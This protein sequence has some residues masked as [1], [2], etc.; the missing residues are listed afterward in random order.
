M[1][2]NIYL[3]YFLTTAHYSW[4]WLGIWVLFYLNFT[5]YTGIGWIETVLFGSII[6]A[7][8]P[9]GAIGDL[10][11]K[12]KTLFVSFVLATISGFVMAYAQDLWG[13][14]ISMAIGAVGGALYSGTSEAL[15]Y[16]SLKQES[17]EKKFDKIIANTT[18]I[19]FLIPAI[20][21]VIGGFVY[22]FDPKMPFILNAVFC[23]LGAVACLFLV[24]PK[25]DSEVFSW[26]NFVNQTK[27]GFLQLTKSSEMISQVALLLA[28]STIMVLVFEMLDSILSIELGFDETQLGILWAVIYLTTAGASQLTPFFL[29][30]GTKVAFVLLGLLISFSLIISPWLTLVTGGLILLIRSCLD[31][32]FKNVTSVYLNSITESKY[33]ATTLSTFSMIK[34]IPYAI[35]ALLIGYLADLYSGAWVASILGLLL[36]LIIIIQFMVQPKLRRSNNLSN[37]LG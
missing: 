15:I 12:K 35:S 34:N 33:R 1:S 6:L 22:A 28:I 26:K 13:L 19:A 9:T 24:E 7:E 37:S 8:I 17:Q 30:K 32:I 29:K 31:A 3:S 4:F 14:I 5:D 27:Q 36:F 11:G 10:L 16:D 23:G 25:V 2:R 18:S 20:C 21:S